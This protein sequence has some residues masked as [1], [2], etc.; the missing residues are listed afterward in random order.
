MGSWVVV[1]GEGRPS[2]R[3]CP[4][5]PPCPAGLWLGMLVC[6]ILATRCASSLTQP[7]WT[8]SGLQREVVSSRYQ[9]NHARHHPQHPHLPSSNSSRRRLPDDPEGRAVTA[10]GTDWH[11]CLSS[12]WSTSETGSLAFAS[13]AQ[14][15]KPRGVV[16]LCVDPVLLASETM[17]QP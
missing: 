3:Q 13:M 6:V 1:W 12:S 7:G 9:G 14:I 2:D 5:S 10:E 11:P 4:H 16:R 17:D 15:L 8:G